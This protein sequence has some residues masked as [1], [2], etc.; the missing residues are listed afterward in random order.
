MLNRDCLEIALA[1]LQH[2]ADFCLNK[3]SL[4]PLWE[5][6]SEITTLCLQKLDEVEKENILLR[7]QLIQSLELP[8]DESKLAFDEYFTDRYKKLQLQSVEELQY[9]EAKL[10]AKITMLEDCQSMIKQ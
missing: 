6:K 4:F 8:K 10:Q 5:E 1:I 9:F 7:E 2:K 3:F